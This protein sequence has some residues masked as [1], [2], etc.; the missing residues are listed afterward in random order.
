MVKFNTCTLRSKEEQSAKPLHPGKKN[1]CEPYLCM[2]TLIFIGTGLLLIA[3][4]GLA[5]Y[6][7]FGWGKW[8]ES[9]RQ[10]VIT[11]LYTVAK[12]LWSATKDGVISQTEL[13]SIFSAVLGVIAATRGVTLD[14]VEQEFPKIS[15][16]TE[17]PA[18]E[19]E[20]EPEPPEEPLR[21]LSVTLDEDKAINCGIMYEDEFSFPE[22]LELDRRST[23]YA[24]VEAPANIAFYVSASN[25]RGQSRTLYHS[26]GP[27][28][29]SE[30]RR[31]PFVL[32]APEPNGWTVNSDGTDAAYDITITADAGG[33]CEEITIPATITVTK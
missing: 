12:T 20:T 23:I 30:I 11:Q 17:E 19:Q 21:L 24:V 14:E 3:G 2:E 4:I 31:H 16:K 27:E 15:T 7:L 33:Y 22:K 8:P 29:T 5:A 28:E 9:T 13:R 10:A 26:P 25:A 32:K 1:L 18:A 6:L